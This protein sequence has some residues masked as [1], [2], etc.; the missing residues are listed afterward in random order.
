MATIV[1]EIRRKQQ[2]TAALGRLFLFQWSLIDDRSRRGRGGAAVCAEVFARRGVAAMTQAEVKSSIDKAFE[3]SIGRMF[4]FFVSNLETQGAEDATRE[5]RKGFE[6]HLRAHQIA[7]SI[8]E[9]LV[10]A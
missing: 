6:F 7:T 2:I 4:G 5:F 1:P 8:A 9:Q 10:K 3:D